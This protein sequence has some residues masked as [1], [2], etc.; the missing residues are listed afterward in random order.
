MRESSQKS[1][2]RTARLLGFT[3]QTRVFQ[4]E[5]DAPCHILRENQFGRGVPCGFLRRKTDDA[6][7]RMPALNRYDDGRSKAEF[8]QGFTLPRFV[9]GLAHFIFVDIRNTFR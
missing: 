2:L 4:S 9:E 1:S 6:H 3:I 7:D 8:F 5:A